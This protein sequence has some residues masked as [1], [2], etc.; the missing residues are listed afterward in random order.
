MSTDDVTTG[1][2]EGGRGQGD[3]A[4]L[5][6]AGEVLRALSLKL[7]A[8]KPTLNQPYPDALEYTPWSRFVEPHARA[9]YDLKDRIRR[10][11]AAAPSP[12]R[13]DRDGDTGGDELASVP[14]LLDELH[15]ILR[16]AVDELPELAYHEQGARQVWEGSVGAYP[17][18]PISSSRTTL[19]DRC[20]RVSDQL[21]AALA[22]RTSPATETG[23]EALVESIEWALFGTTDGT[24]LDDEDATV[25]V[26]EFRRLLREVWAPRRTEAPGECSLPSSPTGTATADPEQAA[27]VDLNDP[28]ERARVHDVLDHMR[29]AVSEYDSEAFA[30]H[31]AGLVV[32]DT[33]RETEQ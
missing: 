9:A 20:A 12:N 2:G 21:R 10:H 14:E 17:A 5:V 1:T 28:R 25:P 24:L 26:G 16:E 15:D 8:V 3:R 30:R 32:G 22:S 31:L 11:L 18:D 6:E 4:L 19:A 27:A 33:D 13:A 7:L 29:E 23:R